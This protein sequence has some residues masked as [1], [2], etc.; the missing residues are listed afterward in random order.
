MSEVKRSATFERATRA[1]ELERIFNELTPDG[2]AAVTERAQA[3]ARAR[4]ITEASLG[5]GITVLRNRNEI[6]T[7]EVLGEAPG[8]P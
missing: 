7:H 6:L 5:W 8:D 4:G 1:T 3:Q 2:R